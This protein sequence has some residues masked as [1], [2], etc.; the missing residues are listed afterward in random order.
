MLTLQI[1]EAEIAELK[2]EMYHYPDALVQKRFHSIYLKA[3]APEL[4]CQRIGLYIGLSRQKVSAFIQLYNQSGIQ[5]L[6]F[7]N[8]GT[9]KSELENH[10]ETLLFNLE[11]FPVH[12]LS[13]AKERIESLTG[14]QRS[15]S[16]VEFFLKRNDF[17]YQKIGHIPSKVDIQKQETYLEEILN[18][19]IEKAKIGEI[20]L[21]FLDAAHFVMGVFLCNMWSK[22]R[23]F[24]KSSAGRQ[25][26]NVIG[27]LDAVTKKVLFQ[28]NITTVNADA[29]A[30][31]LYYLKSQL[32]DKPIAIVLDN[33]RYQHCNFIKELAT[34]LGITLLFLPPYS[35]N[36]NLIERLWKFTK[37]TVLS[38]KYYEKF[39]KFQVA[40][41]D[42]LSQANGKY[43][44]E[45]QILMTLN[46]QT[47]KNVNIYPV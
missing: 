30:S 17:K 15:L 3:I 10:S 16:A 23:L 20:H 39:D 47:F 28:T 44:K 40:I 45:L 21:L 31:F 2:Y 26:L 35:P 1:S 11:R 8:Y 18:P 33:A 27:T 19:A 41:T 7:N 22:V 42:C 36:L 12:Q 13:Q 38:G 9:N 29:M 6:K 37:K 43:A 25:R 14:I 24:I 32:P 4:S 5:S 34:Q 46:F